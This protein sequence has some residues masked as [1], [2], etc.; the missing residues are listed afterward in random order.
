MRFIASPRRRPTRIKARRAAKNVTSM[1]V[2]ASVAAQALDAL[3]V[4]MVKLTR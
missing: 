1:E 3:I 4:T 2:F